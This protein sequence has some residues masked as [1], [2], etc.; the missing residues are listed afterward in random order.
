MVWVEI[1]RVLGDFPSTAASAMPFA[2]ILQRPQDFEPPQDALECILRPAAMLPYMAWCLTKDDLFTVP[3]RTAEDIRDHATPNFES[4]NVNNY[5]KDAFVAERK[6]L[7][8]TLP[9]RETEYA[10]ALP[11]L[12]ENPSF[13][14]AVETLENFTRHYLWTVAERAETAF[15]QRGDKATATLAFSLTMRKLY[16]GLNTDGFFAELAPVFGLNTR[17]GEVNYPASLHR[18]F[19]GP[20]AFESFMPFQGRRQEFK[21]PFKESAGGLL[22]G[23]FDTSGQPPSDKRAGGILLAIQRKYEALSSP[24]A[25]KD[26]LTP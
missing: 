3:L 21:C 24:G 11:A 25:P 20:G 13:F 6:K 2:E 15:D 7:R 4:P 26:K 16:K 10:T 19:F 9:L 23:E 14:R 12:A 18:T 8:G 17:D 1:D 22:T 5:L